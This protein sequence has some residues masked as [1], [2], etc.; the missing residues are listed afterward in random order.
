MDID[1]PLI[2]NNK[3]LNFSPFLFT[4]IVKKEPRL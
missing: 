3:N 4:Q 2:L 1:N